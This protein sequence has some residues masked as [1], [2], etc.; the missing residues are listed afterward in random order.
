MDISYWHVLLRAAGW[1]D[2]QL[3]RLD[4]LRAKAERGDLEWTLYVRPSLSQHDQPNGSERDA[5]FFGECC[6]LSIRARIAPSNLQ[7]LPIRQ[8]GHRTPTS[9][10]TRAAK[11]R[12]AVP[13]CRSPFSNHVG[14]VVGMGSQEQVI[15]AYATSISNIP[16]RIADIAFM[17]DQESRWNWPVSELPGHPRCQHPRALHRNEDV[18]IPIRKE[19]IS[20]KPAPIRIRRFLNLLPKTCCYW[21]RVVLAMTGMAAKPRSKFCDAVGS[22]IKRGT[23][24]NANTIRTHAE[25]PFGCHA[26]GCLHQPPGFLVWRD[27]SIIP[28]MNAELVFVGVISA[29]RG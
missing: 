16:D 9:L 10:P 5:E 2:A 11:H 22:C 12:M 23:T 18:P 3:G 27:G 24:F 19:T 1:T 7:H 6:V 21:S 29:Y 8:F 4:R 20:P 26:R 13:R 14:R 28:S 17:A 15:G 25:P